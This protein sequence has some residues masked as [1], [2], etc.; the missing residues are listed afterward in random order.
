M[1]QKKIFILL[2][3]SICFCISAFAQGPIVCEPE[4]K[5]ARELFDL[6]DVRI[7]NPQMLNLQT[8]NNEYLISLEV[9]RLLAWFRKEAGL[10]QN[11]YEPYPYWESEN[12]FGGGPLSGH[13]MGFWLSSM[14]MSYK[15]TGD[16]SILPKILYALMGLRECQEADGEGFIGAQPNV[17]A[18][19]DEVRKG[20]FRTTNPLIIPT[21]LPKGSKAMQLWEPVYIMNKVMLGLFDVYCEFKLPLAKTILVDLADWFGKT[22]I[23]KLDHE[24]MQRLLVCEHGSINESFIDVYSITGEKRFLDWANRLNDEDMWVPAKD[25]KDVLHGWHANTQIPK[26]TGFERIYTYTGNEDFSRAAR[27]FW[28]IVTEKHTWANGGNSTGEHFFPIDQFEKKIPNFGGPESCNSVNMM[29][30]TEAIYQNDGDMKYIDYYERILLNQILANFDPEQGMCVYYTPMR[31]AH[32]KVYGTKYD[33]FWCCTGTGMQAPAK[34]GKMIYAKAED[35]VYVNMYIASN[36]NWKEKGLMLSQKTSF[37]VENTSTIII[38]CK[39]SKKATIALRH[40]W[41]SKE[42]TVKVNGKQVTAEEKDGYILISRKWKKSDEITVTLQPELRYEVVPGGK[43]Y[44]AY[45]YGPVLLGTRIA[46]PDLKKEDCRLA[47]RT[48]GG[49]RV[50]MEWAP[51]VTV[52]PEALISAMKRDDKDGVLRFYVPATHSTKEFWLEPYNNIHFSRYAMY[53]HNKSVK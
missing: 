16:E 9:D 42:V 51:E 41:W 36:L 21:N 25:G 5:P 15:S 50:P 35:A 13:I 30:L 14:T 47:R 32:Y 27:F 4:H 18:L 40:P 49:K 43:Y 44:H 29:R 39:R 53:F 22:I 1:K 34:L 3:C 12:L 7:T 10:S 6:K 19:F 45:F 33:S 2:I 24:Q 26:F 46:D 52:S 23:D 17:K 20:D 48:V 31:P 38:D 11:G 28:Q 37:P 8:L